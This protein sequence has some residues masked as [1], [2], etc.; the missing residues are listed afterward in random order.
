MGTSMDTSMDMDNNSTFEYLFPC[1]NYAMK[2]IKHNIFKDIATV[3]IGVVVDILLW[4][5]ILITIIVIGVP[6]LALLII[7][8]ILV[9][10]LVSIILVILTILTIIITIFLLF[11]TAITFGTPMWILIGCVLCYEKI[12]NEYSFCNEL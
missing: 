1:T 2:K 10:L 9:I 6:L 4:L 5:L 8:I 7:I 11:I 12:E 3:F